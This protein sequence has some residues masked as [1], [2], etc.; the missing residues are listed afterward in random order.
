M[1]TRR[2]FLREIAGTT[3]GIVFVG[4]GIV[5]TGFS[6]VQ[7][8]TSGKR[9]AVFVG[10]RRVKT[11]DVH[12]HCQIPS[13]WDSIKDHPQIHT[14]ERPRGTPLERLETIERIEDRIRDLDERGIDVQAI[15][16][17]PFW[18]G[19]ESDLANVIV[20]FQNEKMAEVC[21]ANPERFVGLATVALQHPDLAAQQLEDAVKKLEMRGC[22][23]HANVNGEELSNPKFHPFWAKAEQLGCLVFIHPA[24]FRRDESRFLGNGTLGNVIGNPLDTTV[25]LSHLI[26]EGTLDRF[27]DV[28]ICGAHGGGFLPSYI[29]RSNHCV[30]YTGN[31]PADCK[32]VKKLPSEYLKQ[33]YFDSLVYS[34]EGL[35]HLVAE[36]GSSQILMGT[37]YP[38]GM[39]D[40]KSVDHILGTPSL[41]DTDRVA[42]LGG[43]AAKLL[44]VSG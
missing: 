27:P 25:A 33:L 16:I 19:A 44:K 32:P 34:A 10:G 6:A 13:L 7:A 20:K 39:G 35:R 37:D 31:W 42:I 1:R 30:E 12:S 24:G 18:Y 3:T 14:L 23:I 5:E 2:E 22:L 9:R 28:K 29:A 17:N 36:C 15:S 41:S 40:P 21:A 11:I 8:R 4:C 38:A 43:N 26:F